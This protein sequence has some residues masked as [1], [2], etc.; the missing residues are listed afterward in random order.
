[1]SAAFP[2]PF[3]HL[4]PWRSPSALPLRARDRLV[5][6]W[7]PGLPRA[8]AQ[9]R[10]LRRRRWTVP[11]TPAPGRSLP[12]P[13]GESPSRRGVTA[14]LL[15]VWRAAGVDAALREAWA[16]GVLLLGSSAGAVCWFE[17]S[18]SGTR[19]GWGAGDP[20]PLRDGLGL[21]PGSAC[22]HYAADGARRRPAYTRLVAQGLPDGLPDGLA[23]DDAAALCFEGTALAEVVTAQPGHQAYRLRRD[24]Q[25]PG[26]VEETALPARLLP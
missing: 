24:P 19:P 4:R 11:R 22:A 8:P 14:F 21:L 20:W 1:M 16:A 10:A 25:H 18:L 15:A 13:L 3:P 5:L 17:A 6:S 23:V 12:A 9:L 2:H 26:G 7:P